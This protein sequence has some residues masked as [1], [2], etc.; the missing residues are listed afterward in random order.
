MI[1][2]KIKLLEKTHKR[3][4]Q[5]NQ[6]YQIGR[7]K[8]TNTNSDAFLLGKGAKKPYAHTPSLADVNG[9]GLFGEQFG[10]IQPS[11]YTSYPVFP[12][13]PKKKAQV[14]R[15]GEVRPFRAPSLKPFLP[16]QKD[17]AQVVTLM[18]LSHSLSVSCSWEMAPTS[19]TCSCSHMQAEAAPA[20]LCVWL[21]PISRP[22]GRA[23]L[24]HGHITQPS[25]P[26]APDN[27]LLTPQNNMILP[28]APGFG[29]YGGGGGTPGA[30]T[31][32]NGT[33]PALL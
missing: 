18:R 25:P 2:I 1:E 24:G 16:R 13:D 12:I 15:A 17:C 27:S 26:S 5:L 6:P 4:Y 9:C 28:V 11:M 22:S 29:V 21:R 30:M 14:A 10:N 33:R 23:P 7:S 19:P 3:K 20:R 31:L 32:A 8:K